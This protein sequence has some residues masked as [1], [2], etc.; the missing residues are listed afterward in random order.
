MKFISVYTRSTLL[1]TVATLVAVATF[2]SQAVSDDMSIA[3]QFINATTI[4][5]ARV[6]STR[7]SLP[8][9]LTKKLAGEENNALQR[10]AKPMLETLQECVKAL[11]GESVFIAV[12]VPFSKSQSPVRLM[13]KNTP[14]LEKQK[15]ISLLERFQL[16]KPVAQ[17]DYLCFSAVHSTESS[18]KIAIAESIMPGSRPDL[19]SAMLE[20]R[21]FPIQVLVL[22]PDYLW[23]TIRDLM[24]T[25]PA[26]FG[27]GSSSL[28]T[29]GVKWTAIGVDPSK[30]SM[31]VVTQSRSAESA[32]ALATHLPKF[33]QAVANQFSLPAAKSGVGQIA[34]ILKPIVKGDRITFSTTG[35]SALDSSATSLIRA[36]QEFV[37]PL[38]NQIKM[39]RFKQIGLAIHNFVSANKVLPPAKD[40]RT[41][42]GKCI[43]SWRVHILPYFG[44][45]NLYNQFRLKEPWNSE[46]NLKLL[47][48]MPD[49]YKGTAIGFAGMN[50]LKSGYTTF[51]APEG[52][53]TVFGSVKPVKFSDIK[54]GTS[55]TV[56]L[57]EVKP[58]FAKPWTAPEDYI[59]DVANPALG[60]AE[61]P[62]E[63]STFLAALGD[64]SVARIPLSLPAKSILHLFQ[65]NDGNA[66]EW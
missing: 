61:I 20:V 9:S 11:S 65:K 19:E 41:A 31:Q 46:H 66:V 59:F 62:G 8:D 49:M 48:Q 5:I 51:L 39:D 40:A 35:L 27:G 29:E 43:L 2:V 53:D 7:L 18:S 6:D 57:V 34:A 25:I 3:K 24:P 64:G 23:A 4:A 14:R 63:K 47:D 36:M 54:D 17:G 22:P 38:T 56:W 26:V 45:A 1:R 32:S 58:E 44:Q 28:L 13:V 60:L 50:G 33:M 52:D 15:L 42:D 30:L 55:N 21:D 10:E 16:S 37:G 12:D